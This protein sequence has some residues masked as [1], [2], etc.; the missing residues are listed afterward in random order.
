[1]SFQTAYT[2]LVVRHNP[3]TYH[4]PGCF[5]SQQLEEE[6]KFQS[7]FLWSRK[8]GDELPLGYYLHYTHFASFL[9]VGAGKLG[10]SN[11]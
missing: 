9:C 4:R 7:S 11:C 2:C 6:F 5:C 10:N 1:M 3:A 8:L